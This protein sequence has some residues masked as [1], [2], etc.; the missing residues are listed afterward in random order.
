MTSTRAL[1]VVDVQNDFCEGGSLA[2]AG[3]AAV[4]AGIST[5]LAE[6]A[7]DFAAVVAS[8]DWHDGDSSNSGHFAAPGEQPD[9]VSTWPVHCVAGTDG[10]DYHPALDTT[11][12]THHV[13]KGQG[14]PA[15]SLFEGTVDGRPVSE[16]VD[17]LGA[18]AVTVVGIATDYCVRASAL[19]ALARGL[20]VTVLTDLVAGV[21]PES[22]RR[23]LEELEASG[24]RLDTARAPRG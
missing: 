3:G 24:A 2:V 13:R 6:H 18:T 10:A 5:Y 16:V 17:E 21:D 15:Y 1:L 9:Y 11:P 4:A 19:D 23:A 12:V 22:S 20:E 7:G 8:R 14:V